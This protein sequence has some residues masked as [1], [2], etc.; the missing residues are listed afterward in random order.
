[1]PDDDLLLLVLAAGPIV[2]TV[3]VLCR[4][5]ASRLSVVMNALLAALVTHAY[6]VVVDWW[7]VGWG[8]EVGHDVWLGSLSYW[9]FAALRIALTWMAFALS[10]L[11]L[12]R[13]AGRSA[14]VR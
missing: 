6:F 3:A 13:P 1:M 10:A 2:V 8:E 12:W 14:S 11:T 7:E 4:R 9:T 5:S